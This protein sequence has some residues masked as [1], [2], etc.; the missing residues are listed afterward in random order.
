MKS[1]AW[2]AMSGAA[3]VALGLAWATA[4][5]AADQVAQAPTKVKIAAA[6]T[7]LVQHAGLEAAIASNAFKEEGLEVEVVRFR[8]WTEPVQ[9]IASDA[10][11]FALGA[12]SLA[13]AVA[14]QNA[15]VRQIA[16]VSSYHPYQF[17]VKKDSGIK[18]IADVRGKTIQ[19][20]RPGET[21]DNV[22]VQVMEKA[23]LKMSDVKRVESFNG[24]GTLASGTADVANLSS[25]EI[26]K[27]RQLGFVQ[28]FDYNEWRKQNGLRFGDGAN[29]GWGT[30]LKMLNEQP[31]TVHAFLRAMAKA[32]HKLRTDRAFAVSVLKGQPFQLDDATAAEVWELHKDHWIVRMDIERGDYS[33]DT[34]MIAVAMGKP[35]GSIDVKSV[36]V[37]EPAREALKSLNLQF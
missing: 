2:R 35:P 12:A 17:W 10:A 37:T 8:S 14:G 31:K 26:G 7:V 9:A 3:C 30:S 20:V 13:R 11:Q 21:L 23:G 28:I 19:T 29:L 34:E 25:V 1:L 24:F 18:S 27:A 15:P 16:M 36:A 33:F 6:L 32:T 22:W 5:G 4:A